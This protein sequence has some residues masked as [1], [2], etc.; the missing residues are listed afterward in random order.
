MNI[1]TET[2]WYRTSDGRKV[3]VH[4][5]EGTCVH[6]FAVFSQEGVYLAP[7]AA[8]GRCAPGYSQRWCITG[9]WKELATGTAWVNVYR[10]SDGTIYLG[11]T[12]HS[13]ENADAVASDSSQRIACAKIEWTEGDGL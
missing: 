7:M 3:Q 8:D 6:P 1:V 12:Q 4:R 10:H 9:P 13:R 5:L 2:G 11:Q